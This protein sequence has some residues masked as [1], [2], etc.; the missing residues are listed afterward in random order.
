MRS[1]KSFISPFAL[2]HPGAQIGKNVSIGAGSQISDGV[3]IE[4]SVYIGANSI[5]GAPPAHRKHWGDFKYRVLIE[6][7][8]IIFDQ[9]HIACGTE[10][11]TT[12]GEGALLMAQIHVAHDVLIGKKVTVAPHV[13]LAGFVVLMTGCNLGMGVSIHQKKIIPPFV[14]AGMNSSFHANTRVEPYKTYFGNPARCIGDNKAFRPTSVEI[15]KRTLQYREML[16]LFHDH[17]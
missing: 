17:T 6:K 16:E 8:A 9:V 13:S 4:D 2:I 14:M 12:I 5:I 3:V 10:R 1:S 11:M 7:K 15:R